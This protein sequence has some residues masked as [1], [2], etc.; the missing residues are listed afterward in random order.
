MG[1][2]REG[3]R[4]T[5]FFHARATARKCTNKVHCFVR[6][7]GSL[8]DSQME[9]K[10]MMHKSYENLFTSDPCDDANVVFYAISHKFTNEMIVDLCKPYSNE[11]IKTTLFHM[12]PTK[13]HGPDGLPALFYHSLEFF[14]ATAVR[15][16]LEGRSIAD[17]F[18]DSVIMLIPKIA[19][20][21]HLK[22]FHPISL[23]NFL[24][25][26]ASK[27]LANRLKLLLPVVIFE[28]Q[29]AFV[30]DRLIID[31]TLI[32]YESLHTIKQQRAKQPFFAL[33]IDM[34]KAY[35]RVE[36][37]YLHSCLSRYSFNH[38]WINSMMRCVTNV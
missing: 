26:I 37:S 22:N 10:S 29:S 36:W 18:C 21:N 12:G 24:Y 35:D 16:L 19:R 4:D 11:E 33:K 6:D 17:A 3:D 9:I 30:P 13:A 34:M 8:C 15:S 7:D 23:C 2:L 27:V 32:A 5:N 1:W 20:A 38:T 31:N 28:F 14:W 25:K